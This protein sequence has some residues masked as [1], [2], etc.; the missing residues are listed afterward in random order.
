M[1]GMGWPVSK[2]LPRTSITASASG[3]G[4][5]Q[6]L[7]FL[8]LC[9]ARLWGFYGEYQWRYGVMASGEGGG[10]TL[11]RTADAKLIACRNT[12]S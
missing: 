9:L 2:G 5:V 12:I 1:T 10:L 4:E 8:L 7:R 11:Y 6:W 3:N